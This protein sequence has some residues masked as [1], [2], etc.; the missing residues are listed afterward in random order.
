MKI[1]EKYGGKLYLVI[2]QHKNYY[3]PVL[4]RSAINYK[5]LI[6]KRNAI[7]VFPKINSSFFEKTLNFL[8]KLN[9]NSEVNLE[10]ILD[11]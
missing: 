7:A 2:L 3:E 11:E 4:S 10:R 5:Y 1:P 6:R 9:F 8:D